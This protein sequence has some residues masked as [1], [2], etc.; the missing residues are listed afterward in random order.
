MGSRG[1][2][3]SPETY[4]SLQFPTALRSPADLLVFGLLGIVLTL[5]AAM[6]LERM[7]I[8]ARTTR[9]TASA[10]ESIRFAVFHLTGGL[11]LAGVLIALHT[12]TDDVVVSASVD[13]LHTS[14][15]PWDAGRIG[16]LAGLLLWAVATVWGGIAVL[17]ATRLLWRHPR[18]DI[19]PTAAAVVCWVLP[20]LAV[21]TRI[22]DAALPHF[23]LLAGVVGGALAV[24]AIRPWFRHASHASRMLALFVEVVLPTLLLY[25]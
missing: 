9:Q 14:L 1:T 15:F 18:H 2:L 21:I 20:S 7:R 10:A 4:S 8:A 25:P 6:L 3:F 17:V 11:V 13:L 5:T 23:V 24:P 12:L 19:G 16:V 22:E